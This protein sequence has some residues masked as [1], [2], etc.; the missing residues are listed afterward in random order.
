MNNKKTIADIQ[1]R[2]LQQQLDFSVR[3]LQEKD[4]QLE[5]YKQ[6]VEVLKNTLYARN[7]AAQEDRWASHS[8]HH[9]SRKSSQPVRVTK[10]R[11]NV[12]FHNDVEVREIPQV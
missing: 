10:Q 4:E 7:R 8:S 2:N 12:S 6:I 5:Y 11:K 9:F 3:Q 1:I